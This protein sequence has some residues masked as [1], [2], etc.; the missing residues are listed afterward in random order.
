MPLALAGTIGSI[1]CHGWKG[2]MMGLQDV[3][4]VYTRTGGTASGSQ[5]VGRRAPK[6]NI[7]T[8]SVY[9][10]KAAATTARAAIQAMQNTTVTVVDDYGVTWSARVDGQSPIIKACR[11]PAESGSATHRIECDWTLEVVA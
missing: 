1:R 6:S 7:R 8:M 10:S 4:D 11:G 9:S 2:Q 5:S 3:G